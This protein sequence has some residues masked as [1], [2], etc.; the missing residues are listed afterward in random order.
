VAR[1]GGAP[2]GR[3]DPSRRGFIAEIAGLAGSG[4]STVAGLLREK[5]AVDTEL[6]ASLAAAAVRR[7][8]Q[9]ARTALHAAGPLLREPDERGFWFDLDLLAQADA[10][11]PALVAASRGAPRL[12][13]DQGPLCFCAV[14][15]F[16]VLRTPRRRRLVPRAMR[17]LDAFA[18]VLD[19][20]V[21]LDARDEILSERIAARAKDHAIKGLGREQGLAY[22]AG[23]REVYAELLE[24]LAS[25]FGVP[26][27]RID[28]GAEGPDEVARRAAAE[29]TRLGLPDAP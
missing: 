13:L 26:I 1:R 16:V 3:R 10:L 23:F 9:V 21:W 8:R 18:P 29:L 4:K 15:R 14:S 22:L 12:L 7:A 27:V 24:H 2:S 20:V 17:T 5:L 28:T 11:A 6:R 19:A 25:A